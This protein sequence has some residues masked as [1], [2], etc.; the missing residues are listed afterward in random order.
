MSYPIIYS[1]ND[2]NFIAHG[3]NEELG[4]T[5]SRLP[6]S[7]GESALALLTTTDG[8][9]GYY[10]SDGSWAVEATSSSLAQHERL[11][12]GFLRSIGVDTAPA[13]RVAEAVVAKRRVDG[14]SCQGPGSLELYTYRTDD[15]GWVTFL[16]PVLNEFYTRNPAC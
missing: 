11:I 7:N 15:G 4:G 16:L 14:S 12:A 10:Y 3:L 5:W 6:E 9:V 2:L 1:L 13:R 8:Y